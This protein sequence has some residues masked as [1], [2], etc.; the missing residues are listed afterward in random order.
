MSMLTAFTVARIVAIL[1]LLAT[2]VG[3]PYSYYT[4]LRFI[5]C[6]TSALGCYLAFNINKSLENIWVWIFG[7]ITFLFNPLIPI[8]LDKPTWGIIDIITAITLLSSLFLFR[9][10]NFITKE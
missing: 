5:T 3:H 8:H 2:I 9:R 6:G 10:S 7:A 4:L 1:M